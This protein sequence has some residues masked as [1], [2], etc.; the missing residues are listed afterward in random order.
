M[1]VLITG[2]RGQVGTAVREHLAGESRYRFTLLDVEP[3]P[4]HDVTVADVADYDEMRPAF[5]GQDAVVHLAASPKPDDPWPDVLRDNIVGTYNV[6]EAADDAGVSTVVF[7][8]S[9]HVQ[10]GYEDEH[11]PE[12]YEPDYP[13]SVSVSDPVRPDSYYAVSKLFGEHLG[14]YYVEYEGVDQFYALRIC[15]VSHAEWDHPWG[16]AERGVADGSYERDSETYQRRLARHMN[17]WC[18]RRDIAQLVDRCL[19][20]DTVTFDAFYGVSGNE[21]TWWDWSHA[22]TVLGYDPQDDARSWDRPPESVPQ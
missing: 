1:N 14:Q 17:H 20:D 18:S 13:L 12:L 4:E 8:S 10:G 9:H 3:D 6:L 15:N 22:A 21:G 11:A 19:Q 7:A 5:D 2:A 16:W